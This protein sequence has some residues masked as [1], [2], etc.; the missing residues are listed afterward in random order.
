MRILDEKLLRKYSRL[1]LTQGVGIKG[2]DKI[3][4]LRAAVVGCGATGSHI[5]EIL[6]RL[7]VGYIRVID[8]DFVD[9][10]NLYRMSLVVEEDAEKSMPKAVACA[11]RARTINSDVVVEPVVEKLE[12]SNA[13]ELLSGV[14]VVFDGTDNFRARLLID[15]VAVTKGIPWVYVGVEGWYANVML[16]VPRSGPCLHCLIEKP[17][18]REEVNACDI[19]GVFP[20]VIAMASSLAVSVAL[21]HLLGLGDYAGI[22]Y[23]IDGSRMVVDAIRVHR[24]SNCSLCVH[25]RLRYLVEPRHSRWEAKPVCG[26]EAV[27]VKPP[28][29]LDLDL[30]VLLKAHRDRVVA[31]NPYL[32]RIKASGVTVTVFRTGRAIVDGT[33]DVR[34]AIKA[35]LDV[36]EPLGVKVALDELLASK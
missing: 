29:P 2:V 22:L 31:W 34:S 26:T 12:P 6:S 13:V 21:R 1:I 24:R 9:Y 3:R 8:G 33:T 19:I 10:S 16:I 30:T 20:T 36:I 32:V 18:R 35:Y 11:E 7:G 23:V 28:Q 17:P 14:D 5:V 27:E 25:G 15:E 4:K